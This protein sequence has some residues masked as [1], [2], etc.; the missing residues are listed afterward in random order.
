MKQSLVSIIMSVYNGEPYLKDAIKSI[1]KQTFT[2]FELLIMNDGSKDKSVDILKKYKNIDRRI[3]IYQQENQG[4]I[5]SLNSLIIK[6]KGE[7][8]ARHDADDISVPTRLQKQIN[9]LTYHKNV[10]L[11]GSSNFWFNKDGKIEHII[12]RPPT[13]ELITDNLP[14]I[15]TICH[16]T[17]MVRKTDLIALGCYD[18]NALH[19]EDYDLWCRMA[20]GKKIMANIAEPLYFYRSYN[21]SITKQNTEKQINAFKKIRLQ[22]L[23][24]NFS[25]PISQTW[26]ELGYSLRSKYISIVKGI[27]NI[28]YSKCLGLN[29]RFI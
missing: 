8:I 20:R 24:K 25:Y 1:I 28:F 22:Y 21:E 6:A 17:I 26:P 29:V 13:N 4:L 27:S 12:L 3:K 23:G 9:F 19:A 18:I 16:G 2:N 5:R 7:Y 11:V 10:S 14:S 15:N